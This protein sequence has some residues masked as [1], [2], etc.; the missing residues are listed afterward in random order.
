MNLTELRKEIDQVDQEIVRLLEERMNI[1][2]KIG[3]AKQAQQITI[4]DS[5]REETVL[6]QARQNVKN[7][8]YQETIVNTYKDI[9][10]N[11]RL[12]QKEAREK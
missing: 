1:V 4:L 7:P 2:Q 8:A 3:Q 10:K 5:S 9:M 11:S 12:Y 6:N